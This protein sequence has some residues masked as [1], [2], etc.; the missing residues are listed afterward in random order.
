M[1][2]FVRDTE[3]LSMPIPRRKSVW[4]PFILCVASIRIGCALLR[5]LRSQQDDL[6]KYFASYCQEHDASLSSDILDAYK[7]IAFLHLCR[8]ERTLSPKKHP[9]TRVDLFC[10]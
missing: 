3:K 9:H 10:L 4:N 2:I 1:T 7:T 8:I 5:V 6:T